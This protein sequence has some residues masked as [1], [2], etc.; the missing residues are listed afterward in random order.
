MIR[1]SAVTCYPTLS[2]CKWHLPTTSLW[3]T[4]SVLPRKPDLHSLCVGQ[5]EGRGPSSTMTSQLPSQRIPRLTATSR[6]VPPTFLQVVVLLLS[7]QEQDFQV[8]LHIVRKRTVPMRE[9][10]W[11]WVSWSY[12][13]R[14]N[15]WA[16]NAWLYH[17]STPVG[18]NMAGSPENHEQKDLYKV[19]SDTSKFSILL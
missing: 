11:K 1:T 16:L 12:Y 10:C 15:P 7:H 9:T 13:Y 6:P 19:I 17:S 3:K 14:L 8:S 5:A 2:K 4:S 18:A